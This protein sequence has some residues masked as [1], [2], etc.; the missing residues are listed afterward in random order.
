[1]LQVAAAEN[2]DATPAGQLQHGIMASISEWYSANLAQE[3]MEGLRTKAMSGGTTGKAPIGYRNV[4]TP[5]QTATNY[6]PWKPTPTG[7]H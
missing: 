2:I 5:Q 3:V 4:R 7:R 6:A 1:M